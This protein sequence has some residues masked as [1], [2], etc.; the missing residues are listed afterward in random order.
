MFSVVSSLHAAV[1]LPDIVLGE[2]WNFVAM[3]VT[4]Y[5]LVVLFE[6]FT[7]GI[8]SAANPDEPTP[9]S[10]GAQEGR[11]RRVTYVAGA[12]A[13]VA[14]S[15]ALGLPLYMLPAPIIGSFS[16]VSFFWKPRIAVRRHLLLKFSFRCRSL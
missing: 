9:A 6:V 16:A 15:I 13:A 7:G 4:F 12:V 14:S 1:A 3:A 8:G 2:P 10:S 11:L 5:A